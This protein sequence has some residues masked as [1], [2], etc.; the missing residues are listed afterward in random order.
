MIFSSRTAQS[1]GWAVLS[2]TLFYCVSPFARSRVYCPAVEE[3]LL[4]RKHLVEPSRGQVE[5]Q[6]YEQA[7]KIVC[8]PAA[9]GRNSAVARLLQREPE[10]TKTEKK[11]KFF[12]PKVAM[13]VAE[14]IYR[15]E[16]DADSRLRPSMS[17]G[18]IACGKDRDI[19][20]ECGTNP[21]TSTVSARISTSGSRRTSSSAK[22]G[23]AWV[24]DEVEAALEDINDDHRTLAPSS[25]T[26]TTRSGTP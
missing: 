1:D 17:T 8:S 14:E 12:S 11:E 20:F 19:T 3:R 13:A 26:A 24:T 22:D 2:T 7:P 6:A 21:S 16:C 10:A 18:R 9:S 25:R 5:Q 15:R 23:T 4:E